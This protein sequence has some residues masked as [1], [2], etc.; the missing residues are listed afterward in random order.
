MPFVE[1]IEEFTKRQD[2][3][4]VEIAA[5]YLFANGSFARRNINGVFEDF[6]EPPGN[7]LHIVRRRI[8]FVDAKLE[9]LVRDYEN[10]RRTAETQS[11]LHANA[12]GPSVPEGLIEWLK[13]RASE[14]ESLRSEREQLLALL[15]QSTRSSAIEAIEIAKSAARELSEEVK[16]LPRFTPLSH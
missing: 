16:N 10:K 8:D 15:P 5:S 7:P 11:V 14:I 6:F 9:K 12:V 3:E 4:Y 13:Q 2:C 1:D